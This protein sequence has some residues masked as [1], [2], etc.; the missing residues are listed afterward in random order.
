MCIRDSLGAVNGMGRPMKSLFCMVLYYLVIRMPLA[1]LLSNVGLGLDGIW[2]AVLTS[3][4]VAAGA[5]V[6]LGRHLLSLQE[7]Y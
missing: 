7:K 6:F 1:W 2:W 5:A 3:H 4:I